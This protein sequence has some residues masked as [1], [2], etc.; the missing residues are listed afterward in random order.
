MK[1]LSGRLSKISNLGLRFPLPPLSSYCMTQADPKLSTSASVFQILELQACTIT[2]SKAY[3]LKI[4][5]HISNHLCT[6][7]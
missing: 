7:C 2:S 5:K 3:F 4:R 1:S 6:E